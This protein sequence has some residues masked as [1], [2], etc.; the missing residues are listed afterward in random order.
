M[1][2]LRALALGAVACGVLAYTAAT[3]TA[4]VA[5]SSGAV[6]ELRI[7]PVVVLVVEQLDDRGGAVTTLG[8]G[9]ILVALAGGVV[10]AAAALAIGWRE[11]RRIR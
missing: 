2:W 10:N 8:P 9:L 7:G 3:V 4:I 6:L 1:L 5:A 11:R